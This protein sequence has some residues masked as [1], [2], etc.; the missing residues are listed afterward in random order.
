MHS[1]AYYDAISSDY[2]FL[3]R[4]IRLLIREFELVDLDR[5]AEAQA[6]KAAFDSDE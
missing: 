5:R 6:L 4:L 2:A 1:N 3:P